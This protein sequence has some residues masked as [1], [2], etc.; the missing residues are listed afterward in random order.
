MRRL[1]LAQLVAWSL[2]SGACTETTKIRTDSATWLAGRWVLTD[3][4]RAD[5]GYFGDPSQ[6]GGGPLLFQSLDTRTLTLDVTRLGAN[7][8]A[9]TGTVT[10]R[11]EVDCS[12]TL[13]SYV[14]QGE[15]TSYSDTLTVSGDSLYGLLP[16]PAYALPLPPALTDTLTWQADSGP[17][18]AAAQ[19]ATSY[20]DRF[21]FDCTHR[22]HMVR[23]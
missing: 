7:S 10:A 9:V 5:C 11:R 13:Y 6:P 2:A 23:P 12:N 18:C 21:L 16:D 3:T 15:P 17:V 1:A 14:Q 22:I 20:P 8:L 4:V 19:A